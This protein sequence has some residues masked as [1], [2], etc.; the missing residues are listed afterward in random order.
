MWTITVYCQGCGRGR[1]VDMPNDGAWP[2]CERCGPTSWFTADQPDERKYPYMLT[3]N[4]QR[5]LRSLKIA[6]TE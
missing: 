2:D 6:S 3:H 4:D 5:L 1:D